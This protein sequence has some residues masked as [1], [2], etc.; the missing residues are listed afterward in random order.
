MIFLV[1][2][3]LLLRPFNEELNHTSESEITMTRLMGKNSEYGHI[4]MKF[5]E[6]DVDY[7][8]GKV[9]H[10]HTSNLAV[11]VNTHINEKRCQPSKREKNIFL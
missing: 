11:F 8:K 2:N 5:S 6:Q 9:Y 10:L 3:S 4:E 7:S 1:K